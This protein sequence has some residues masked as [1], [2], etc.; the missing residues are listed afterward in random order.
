MSTPTLTPLITG[1][2]DTLIAI[3]E[4]L[5]GTRV[6]IMLNSG[7]KLGGQL[8][9]LGADSLHLSHLSGLDFYDAAIRIADITAVVAKAR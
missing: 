9:S 5:V 7:Q 6:E 1:P 8:E 4:R 2:S 3:L